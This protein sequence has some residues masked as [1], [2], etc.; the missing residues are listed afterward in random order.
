MRHQLQ[1]AARLFGVTA[2]MRKDLGIPQ[3]PL[4]LARYVNLI[5]SV[6][7]ELGDAHWNTEWAHGQQLTPEQA[8]TDARQAY[9]GAST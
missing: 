5:A 9:G 3:T 1:R 7:A 6:Q 2:H 4:E 8:V